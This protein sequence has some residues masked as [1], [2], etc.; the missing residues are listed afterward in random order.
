MPNGLTIEQM[1]ERMYTAMVGIDG[2]SGMVKDVA[3]GK[4]SRKTIY[5]RIDV[6]EDSMITKKECK[7]HR[8][9]AISEKRNRWLV[10]KDILL[11]IVGPAGGAGAI[12]LIL[13]YWGK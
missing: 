2:K 5:D 13:K 4:K 11:I 3:D 7:N 8:N 9:H 1:T 10:I 12:V 6:I